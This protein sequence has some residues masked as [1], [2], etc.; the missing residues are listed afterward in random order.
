MALGLFAPHRSMAESQL[1]LP[2]VLTDEERHLF[3]FDEAEPQRLHLRLE[4][5]RGIHGLPG[6]VQIPPIPLVLGSILFEPRIGRDEDNNSRGIDKAREPL[7][8]R[9][10][11][12]QPTKKIAT[13]DAIERTEVRRRQFAGIAL[14]EGDALRVRS[15]WQ[16]HHLVHKIVAL[17]LDRDRLLL[18][19]LHVLRSFDERVREVQPYDLLV[20]F[21]KLKRACTDGTPQIEGKASLP[22]MLL[23]QVCHAFREIERI[24]RATII[25]H[26][27]P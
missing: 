15:F 18:P 22:S 3:L 12:G 16:G 14:G 8:Q 6:L 20:M 24:L 4:C 25:R 1:K 9:I 19:S 17:F 27:I 11:I 5:G 7:Q 26:Q 13:E 23:A 21:A 10:G 2:R